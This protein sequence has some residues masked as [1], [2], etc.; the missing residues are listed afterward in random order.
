MSGVERQ[1][2]LASLA[3]LAAIPLP[4]TGIATWWFVTLFVAVA[5]GVLLAP[6]VVPPIPTWVEN[7][8]APL[9]VAAVIA[10]G[11]LRY[12]V[13]RPVAHLALLVATIRLPGCAGTGRAL[14]MAIVTTIIGTAG[15]ASSTHPSLLAYLVM[16]MAFGL[17]AAGRMALV[18]ARPAESGS[19]VPR[20]WTPPRTVMV[21]IGLAALIALPLFAAL[22]RLRSPFAGV[23]LGTAG[24]SGYR[25]DITLHG[26]G[27][28]KTSQNVAL[29]I[30]FPESP[31]P[32][33]AW[34][35]L[36]GATLFHYRAG[37]WVEGRAAEEMPELAFGQV[38]TLW[39]EAGPGPR[40]RAEVTLERKGESLFLPLGSIEFEPPPEVQVSRTSVGV[41]RI[42]RN[43]PTPLRYAAR[44]DPRHPRSLQPASL[45]LELPSRVRGRIHPLVRQVVGE[46]ATPVAAALAIEQFLQRE[47]R[48]SLRF[49][50]PV[51]E[52]PVIWFLFHNRVGHCEYFASA[53]ALML[54]S[55]GVPARLQVGF[56]GG[57]IQPDGSF[58]V[59]D[60]H[61][62]AWVLAWVNESWQVFDPTPPEGQ[63]DRESERAKLRLPWR[64]QDL[65]GMWD[66][67]VL[68]FGVPDQI[69][70]VKAAASWVT[71][72]F[73]A[74]RLFLLVALGGVG[75]GLAGR[76]LWQRRRREREPSRHI[77][78][79]L[80]V[81]LLDRVMQKARR[82]GLDVPS[83]LSPRGFERL[84]REAFPSAGEPLTFLIAAHERQR[85]A[86]GGAA[87]RR[88]LRRRAGEILRS[89][90]ANQVRIAG[91]RSA[92]GTGPSSQAASHHAAT[93]NGMAA[94]RSTR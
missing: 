82:G 38:H 66:R 78:A 76:R 84:I 94:K 43:A 67:W 77:A 58:L 50:P 80:V 45:D 4:F 68:T 37:S 12:G 21:T 15:V 91:E 79:D 60:S 54:R 93:R 72:H 24:V 70:L 3:L 75:L 47:Y 62:H 11:G 41:I 61:A 39:P 90:D 48:Y 32:S 57:E 34:L 5:L 59:R 2:W 9:V 51:R 14:K 28:I 23:T 1:R 81:R 27:A 30:R 13:L 56:A 25:S 44:F 49:V 86:G 10:A 26:I 64:W 46:G 35:R 33:R 88:E 22:P 63:P 17:I 52:D 19:T 71:T 8:L 40:V 31:S 36:E 73:A 92:G 29:S 18:S 83:S 20:L 7:I 6:R 89:M 85:Y 74:L 55:V 42:P 87:S 69:E 65:E 16:V 53:M